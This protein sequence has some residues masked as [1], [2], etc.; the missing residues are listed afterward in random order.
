[1]VRGDLVVSHVVRGHLVRRDLVVGHV[2]RRHLV[3]RDL[4]GRDLVRRRLDV[5]APDMSSTGGRA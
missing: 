2:V 3:R 4:V 5:D 1:V